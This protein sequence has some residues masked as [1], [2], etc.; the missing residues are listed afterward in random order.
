MNSED[1]IIAN[2]SDYIDRLCRGHWTSIPPEDRRSEA[3][4]FLLHALR[5]LPTGSRQF[6]DYFEGALEEHMKV[7]SRRYH[8]QFPAYFSLDEGF[9]ENDAELSIFLSDPS[10]DESALR[11]KTFKSS[12]PPEQ[13][14]LLE[15][16]EDGKE[17]D[18]A[19]ARRDACSN[20]RPFERYRRK[21]FARKVV[22]TAGR[23]FAS[24]RRDRILNE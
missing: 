7:L 22:K 8:Q 1:Y 21:L 11:V 20:E 17:T 9:G 24:A 3:T 23:C 2:S 10:V 13:R 5:T 14:L 16:L 4:A 6:L 15:E 19:K 18:R 12:L